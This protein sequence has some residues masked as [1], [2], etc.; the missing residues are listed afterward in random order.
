VSYSEIVSIR[1]S[2]CQPFSKISNIL[3]LAKS[4]KWR[5]EWG[6]RNGFRIHIV[7]CTFM[8]FEYQS[9][10]FLFR[11]VLP[12]QQCVAMSYFKISLGFSSL[13]NCCHRLCLAQLSVGPLGL[14]FSFW[15]VFQ[16][17][18]FFWAHVF[19]MV[20]LGSPL[21]FCPLY[22]PLV[23]MNLSDILSLRT[24]LDICPCI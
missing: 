23:F 8:M 22:H 10:S 13:F 12:C 16:F 17:R 4:M 7:S 15:T 19:F 9:L 11:N 21:T 2:L 24:T 18:F 6:S 5:F 14:L 3:F 20:S 1:Q